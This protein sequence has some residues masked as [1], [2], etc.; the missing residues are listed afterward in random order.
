[1]SESQNQNIE[2]NKEKK[3]ESKKSGVSEEIVEGL[4]DFLSAHELQLYGMQFPK[5]LEQKLF[6]K[7]KYEIFDSQHYFEIM[8]NQDENRYLLRA[9]VNIK[10]NEF[11]CLIDHCWTYK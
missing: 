5:E 7:L 11:V 9:K 3:E 6:T 2:Q 4:K 8:D 1:M 10:K